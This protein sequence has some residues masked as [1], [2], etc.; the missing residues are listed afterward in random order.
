MTF[1]QQFFHQ[2]FMCHLLWLSPSSC[3]SNYESLRATWAIWHM[4]DIALCIATTQLHRWLVDSTCPPWHHLLEIPCSLQLAFSPS[5]ALLQ[6]TSPPFALLQ[7]SSL[8]QAFSFKFFPAESA[9]H[10][11]EA[12][13][14]QTPAWNP[15][16]TGIMLQRQPG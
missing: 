11:H 10:L 16:T 12:F 9:L 5:L 13:K 6:G 15:Q 8:Q 3:A 1:W 7:G 14:G 4:L 2:G